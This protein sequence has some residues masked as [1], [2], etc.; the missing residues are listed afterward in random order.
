[1]VKYR[2]AIYPHGC[3]TATRSDLHE[4]DDTKAYAVYRLM[5]SEVTSRSL[6]LTGFENEGGGALAGAGKQTA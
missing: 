1:M 2:K 6:T 5:R 3:R 4:L